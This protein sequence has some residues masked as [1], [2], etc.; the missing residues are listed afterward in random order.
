MRYDEKPVYRRL[1]IPWFDAKATCF[2]VMLFMIVV[3]WFALMGI[4]V[5]FEKVEHHRHIWV[6]FLLILMSTWVLVSTAIRLIRRHKHHSSKYFDS[7]I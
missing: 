4:D 6:P 2:F 1:I 5:A 3:I 7:K